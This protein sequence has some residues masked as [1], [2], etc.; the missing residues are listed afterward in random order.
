M[1]INLLKKATFA[2]YTG[3]DGV[4]QRNLT[5]G[6][7]NS[8][9]G[10]VAATG[11]AIPSLSYVGLEVM[12]NQ[13]FY[14]KDFSLITINS[15]D[16]SCIL[17]CDILPKEN[18]VWYGVI[19][20][21]SGGYYTCDFNQTLPDHAQLICG[22][23]LIYT[24]L[25]P[26]TSYLYS[27]SLLGVDYP[28]EF[29]YQP[30]S[31]VATTYPNSA[32][33]IYNQSV[34]GNSKDIG[35]FPPY[36]GNYDFDQVFMLT[37]S[38]Q[39]DTDKYH[40]NR[41][42]RAPED[43]P[44]SS[45]Y[46]LGGTTISGRY[47]TLS[48]TSTSGSWVSP[49]IYMPDPNYITMYLYTE[50][51]SP[52]AI[53]DKTWTSLNTSQVRASDQTPLPNFLIL[54]FT[55]QLITFSDNQTALALPDRRST[56]TT[57]E[58]PPGVIDA[59]W[60]QGNFP[61]GGSAGIVY[62]C[63]FIYG[64]SQRIYMKGDG[65]VIAQNI[66]NYWEIS[67]R[68][69]YTGTPFKMAGD[70]NDYWNAAIY[71]GL[72]GGGKGACDVSTAYRGEW[73]SLTYAPVSSAT[74]T[75]DTWTKGNKTGSLG[76]AELLPFFLHFHEYNVGVSNE[77]TTF[78]FIGSTT[79][80]MDRHPNE[81]AVVNAV[82]YPTILGAEKFMCIYL[83]NI[84]N[85][86]VSEKVTLGVYS[87][88]QAPCDEG[89]AVSR[90]DD[91]RNGSGDSGIWIHV[92]YGD[93]ILNKFTFDGELLASYTLKRSYSFMRE[94]GEEGGLWM[95]R[96]D[97]IFYYK[98]DLISGAMVVQFIIEN[99]AF[100]YLYSGDVDRNG[101]LWVV[102]RDT[103]TI[104]RINLLSQSIDY[105]NH[106][107]YAMGVWPHP[108]DGSAYVYIGFDP[109]TFGTVI[110]RVW[111]DDPYQ[112]EE[113][114]TVV[115]SPP[116]SD[117]SGVQFLGKLTGNYIS[118]GVDDPIWGMSDSITLNW[119]D[120]VTGGLSIPDGSYKQF[121]ITLRRSGN[122]PPKLTRI[123]IPEPLILGGVPFQGSSP[124]YINPHLRYDIQSGSFTSELL[125]WWRH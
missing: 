15:H 105:T 64:S 91:L 50:N 65:E 96:N 82:M 108:T 112:Y 4:A 83:L 53:V 44:W 31:V 85:F 76:M 123:R 22:L 8:F 119:E 92:G 47:L 72:L 32:I 38:G 110:K 6:E 27:A 40:V 93:R 59:S 17:T 25:S 114:V 113:L 74:T 111:A 3:L 80:R 121:R 120:Y 70:I 98:E 45:G 67:E 109:A 26:S 69:C 19:V 41:G 97:G 21:Q 84:R 117:L 9:C 42:I 52:T 49:V 16:T 90:C 118:P 18:N 7:V 48:G 122:I 115:P 102:D 75:P 79:I 89:Y 10:N 94:S 106:I 100:E 116:L 54:S 23:R 104:Y 2:N 55:K 66:P 12:L 81:W 29:N 101:N 36:T 87:M 78:D 73:N 63:P 99:D 86:W 124:V 11:I 51:T 13:Y 33:D 46:L 58:D 30:F 68:D 35:V 14:A 103:S 60:Y 28:I 88:G 37:V 107:P 20:T 43:I 125:T 95:I 77:P 71:F 61:C 62:P 39:D 5:R 56:N 34:Q 1:S 57:F 24:N